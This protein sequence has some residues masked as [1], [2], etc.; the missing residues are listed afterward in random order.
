MKQVLKIS[1]NGEFKQYLM[2]SEIRYIQAMC[3]A[4]GAI[5]VELVEITKKEYEIEFGK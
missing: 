5:T 3:T 1:H 4:W 2:K